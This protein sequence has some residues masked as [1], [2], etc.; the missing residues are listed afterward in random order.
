[1]KIS[2]P[3]VLI[4]VLSCLLGANSM[5]HGKV[6]GK[7]IDYTDGDVKL[8]GYLAYDDASQDKRP[9]VLLVHEW[10]GRNDFVDAKARELAALGYVAFALDMYGTGVQAKDAKEAAEW[11]GKF[12]GKPLIRTRAQAGLDVLAR[13]PQADA[14]RIA[15]IGFCF[16]GTTCLELA[17]SGAN[18]KGVASFHGGLVPPAAADEKRIK[19]KILILHGA[20]DTF[21]PPEAVAACE[22]GLTKAG[23][24]W[25]FIAYSGAVHSFTNP[26]ASK[27]NLP[28]TAYNEPAAR[29]SW[30]AMED[31]FKEIFTAKR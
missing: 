8:Q 29:R 31:F 21:V 22:Q 1:M 4:A 3:R 9:G 23:A 10:W 6:V 25:Q 19:A 15:A 20:D 5:A 16:G 17:Y 18:L 26:E 28:G 30:R 24:D 13:Q 12:K 27:R 2:Q 7:T 14:N 11:A